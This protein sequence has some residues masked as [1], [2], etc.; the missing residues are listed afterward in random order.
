MRSVSVVGVGMIRFGRYPDKLVEELGR[1]AVIDAFRDCTATKDDVQET[2]VGSVFAGGGI[3]QRIAKL[4]GMSGMPITNVENACASGSTALRNGWL[5]VASGQADVVLAVGVDKLS[6]G[7]GPL[8][9]TNGDREAAE[10]L[11]MPALYA[12]RAQA[13]MEKFDVGIAEIAQVVVK[14]R[15]NAAMNE[16]SFFRAPVE[17]DEVLNSPMVA[18]PL[19]RYQCCPK[20]DG[21]AAVIL[22]ATER[23]R[24]FTD[25]PV[26]IVASQ[27]CSGSFRPGY[28][29]FASPEISV[30]AA[31]EA[32]ELAGLGPEDID[33]AEIHDA[34]SISELMYY[35]ALQFCAEGDAAKFLGEG[36]ASLGGKLPVNPSGGLIAKGHPPGATGLSQVHEVVTQLRGRAGDRQVEG[37][38]TGLVHCTGGGVSGYD[39]AVASIHVLAR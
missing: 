10:G 33:V 35:E 4:T 34:F 2:F 19:T 7:T 15:A 37:A 30:R 12:M 31:R 18:E 28:R 14:N 21:A 1:D 36:S 20:V 32:Y 25:S 9:A 29:D 26:R 8:V 24:D 39:H 27:L 23:A 38:R 16:H 11:T 17:L 5:A 3:G 22:V 6:G 13:Y